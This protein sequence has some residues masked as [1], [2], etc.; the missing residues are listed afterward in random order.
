MIAPKFMNEVLYNQKNFLK[1][2]ENF[3]SDLHPY[4]LSPDVWDKLKG[5]TLDEKQTVVEDVQTVEKVE[6]VEVAI[7]EVAEV[8]KVEIILPKKTTF[9][10]TL[11]DSIFWCIYVAINGESLY[12]S[13]VKSG[14]N[15]I[16]LMMNEKKRI[17]DHF[18][19]NSALLKNANQK[20]TLVKINE[21]KCNLMTK[22]YMDSIESFIPCSIYYGR[23]IYV[24]FAEIHSY[25]LFVDK[26][27]VSDDDAVDP[28][29]ILMCA[30]GGRFVLEENVAEFIANKSS[31]FHILH[32]EKI[33]SGVSNYKTDEIRAIYKMVF[34]EDA[35]MK[36]PE[37]YEKVLVKCFSMLTAKI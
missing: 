12:Q 5:F 7:V 36:K 13:Q 21:I 20:I 33:L 31:L 26:N 11:K 1:S 30:K 29:I 18:N 37:Y 28:N 15:M 23:P 17:S 25:L 10:S 2:K 22:P 3:L 4:M 8:A 35:V 9:Q 32:Y 19:N 6:V 16:N 27:Y 34:G 24:Y 14:T